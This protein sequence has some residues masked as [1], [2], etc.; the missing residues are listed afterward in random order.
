L[1]WHR[2][3]RKTTL[4]LNLLIRECVKNP[5]SVYG[6]IAPTYTQAK[7][8]IWTDPNMLN[9]YLPH[10][11]VKRKNESELLVEFKNGSILS[12]HGADNP[13]SARGK[14][15]HGIVG[16]EFA[17]WKREMWEEILRPVIAH[18]KNRFAI[19]AFTPKGLNHAYEYWNQS[20]SWE[21]WYKSVLRASE[22]GIIDADA[23]RQMKKE[24]PE[25]LYNQEL[26]CDFLAGDDFTVIRPSDIENLQNVMQMPLGTKR[27][28][29]C[30]PSQGGDACQIYVFENTKVVEEK[31][32]HLNDTMK[33]VGELMLLGSKWK[34]KAYAID[35][36]G[37]GRGIV[38]RLAE[39]KQDVIAVNSA[40]SSGDERFYNRR[41]EMWWYVL[42]LMQSREVEYFKDTELKRQL[43]SVRFK[44]LN[45]NGLLQL[46]P[47]IET[48]KRL[49]RSPDK[50][51]AYIYGLWGLSQQ[52]NVDLGADFELR[53]KPV[54]SGAGG[55]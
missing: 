8:I 51:D 2:R 39:L 49:G 54:F 48:K 19:F 46:E 23:L 27:I 17:L 4:L 45:S 12:I 28:I 53:K 55:W 9:S 22:S 34:T 1:R 44:V 5:K 43:T 30:D 7:G 42:E 3:A 47:K 41:A 21:G 33:I 37:I 25:V 26:E 18:G 24:M 50:A 13:D 32:L 52:P 40:E 31:E 29:S 38:D 15:F 10:E 14:D 11:L 35:S 20:D 16:D 36:I 6:Y